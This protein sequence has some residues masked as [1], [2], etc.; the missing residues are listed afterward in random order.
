MNCYDRI[1]SF[2]GSLRGH[3]SSLF[4]WVF[5]HYKAINFQSTKSLIRLDKYDALRFCE[6][7]RTTNTVVWS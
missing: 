3:G 4:V 2:E 1:P 5:R 7:R 6:Q